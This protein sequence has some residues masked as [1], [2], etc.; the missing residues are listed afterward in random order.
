VDRRDRASPGCSRA[1]ADSP[2]SP[3]RARH[4]G[5]FGGRRAQREC[6]QWIRGPARCQMKTRWPGTSRDDHAPIPPTF[7]HVRH[8]ALV[9]R[10]PDGRGHWRNALA[11]TR[12]GPGTTPGALGAAVEAR[13][14]RGRP[15]PQRRASRLAGVGRLARLG[16]PGEARRVHVPMLPTHPAKAVLLT[17]LLREVLDRRVVG[18]DSEALRSDAPAQGRRVFRHVRGSFARRRSPGVAADIH[19][20]A[21][22][23]MQVELG[24]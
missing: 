21:G 20:S 7:A 12:R 14:I 1:S 5:R 9:W 17:R 11:R 19:H 22:A 8:T 16:V 24:R 4:R 6:P 23:R 3:R 2:S 10:E 13:P 15:P 18:R